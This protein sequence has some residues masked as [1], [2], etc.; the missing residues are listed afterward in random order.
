MPNFLEIILQ[1]SQEHVSKDPAKG[2]LESRGVT[3]DEI[4]QIGLGYFPKEEWPPYFKA[5]ASED[6]DAYLKWSGKGHWLRGKLVFP[7]RNPSGHLVGIQTRSPDPDQK[8]YSK[9]YL[10]RSKVDAVFF[11]IDVAMPHIWQTREVFLCEGIFDFF[12]L[13]RVFPNSVCTGTANVSNK[14]IEFLR[15]FVSDVVVVFDTDWGGNEFFDKF[16]T[17]YKGEFD[18]I[19]RITP[20]GKDIS[21]MWAKMGDKGLRDKWMAGRLS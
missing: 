17:H 8:D 14:Q 3:Q 4:D 11:G 15:R 18:S 12:P 2:Y 9:F 1:K 19:I 7:M 20:Q 10:K 13:H 21:A 5:G 16:N 6:I